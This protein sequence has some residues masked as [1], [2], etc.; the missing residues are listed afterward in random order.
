MR[1]EEQEKFFKK[2][3]KRE[4]GER[5]LSLYLF[6]FTF[7]FST[8]SPT[9]QIL[10]PSTPLAVCRIF[11]KAS[12]YFW[13]FSQPLRNYKI[14]LVH[15][16]IYKY[17]YSYIRE[18]NCLFNLIQVLLLYLMVSSCIII[19]PSKDHQ[20]RKTRHQR[21]FTLSILIVKPDIE[22]KLRFLQG[23]RN[24]YLIAILRRVHLWLSHKCA[25]P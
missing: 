1:T 24:G 10:L 22:A 20:G 11:W 12:D 25:Y 13:I 16:Y 19:L 8:L 21:T 14:F 3:F 17:A 7:W 15:T 4:I 18:S 9:S 6:S 23:F 5:I 2:R